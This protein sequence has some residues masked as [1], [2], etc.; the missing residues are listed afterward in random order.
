MSKKII[1]PTGFRGEDLTGRKFGRLTVV[2]FGGFKTFPCGDRKKFWNCICTC[3]N[4]TNPLEGSIKSRKT[5]SCGCL[6][7]ERR[8]QSRLKHGQNRRGGM[9][10]TYN[11]WK[12]MKRRCYAPGA[13]GYK[14]YGGRGISVCKRWLR[15]FSEFFKDMGPS[16]VGLS[17][18]RI[19]NSGNYTPKNCRW[20][21]RSQQRRNTRNNIHITF[22]GKTRVVEDWATVLGMNKQTLWYRIYSGWD[23]VRALTQPVNKR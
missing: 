10:R 21:T 14:H 23:H 17:L 8:N 13:T 16:P 20:A 3:G 5:E 19:N 11:I 2:G 7:S 4:K 22:N 18:D 15:S 1:T 9:S 12:L 6:G